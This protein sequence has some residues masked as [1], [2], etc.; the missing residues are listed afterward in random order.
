MCGLDGKLALLLI[1]DARLS[2]V[3]VL[4]GLL[5]CVARLRKQA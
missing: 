5:G 1:V 2:C 4:L 3:R